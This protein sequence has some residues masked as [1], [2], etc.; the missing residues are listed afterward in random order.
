M[1]ARCGLRGMKRE[2]EE[3]EQPMIV[4]EGGLRRVMPYWFK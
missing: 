4:V 1:C 2:R 3:E